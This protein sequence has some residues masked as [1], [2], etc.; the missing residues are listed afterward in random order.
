VRVWDL[1]S[2]QSRTLPGS[3]DSTA[4][5][6]S[7]DGHHLASANEDWTV[8]VWDLD[9]GQSRAL[10]GHTSAV[11]AVAYSPDGRH[12]ASAGVDRTVRVWPDTISTPA[13]AIDRICGN[14]NRDLTSDERERYLPS[15]DS[16]SRAC[17][18][19]TR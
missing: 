9:S 3:N 15:T 16:G 8:R 7:P 1:D 6:Y 11:Y 10:T 19:R 18:H 2:G 5:A 14:V 17:P 13:G 12:L 4:V